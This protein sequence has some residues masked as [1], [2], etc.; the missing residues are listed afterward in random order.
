MNRTLRKCLIG[1][2]FAGGMIVLSATAANAADTTSGKDGIL[3]GTQVIAPL[4]A[5]ISTGATSLGLLG[6][7]AATASAPGAAGGSG[8]AP[9]A[10]T[11]GSSSIG[12]GTQVVAPVTVPMNLGSS[13]VGLLGGSTVASP[14]TPAAPA[15]ATGSTPAAGTSGSGGIASGTQ[16]VAPVTVP[17]TVGSTSAGVLGD[18][19][20]TTTPAASVPAPAPAPA[21]AQATTS[22]GESIASGAQV[23]AP[24]SV[25][26][27]IGATAV[28]V[29]G[30]SAASSGS[31]APV[32]P[33]APSGTSSGASTNG[34][35]GIGSG[36][37]VVAPITAP[38]NVG[39]TS[40]GVLGDS[41]AT[42]T[43]TSGGGGPAGTTGGSTTSGNDGLL[44]GTQ[45]IVPITAPVRVG[46]TSVGVGGGSVGTV[47]PPVVTLPVVNPP[48]VT[49][50]VVN[51][52]V[53]TPPVVNPPVVTP[54]VVNPPT[55][56]PPA[57]G[58]L[59]PGGNTGID[60]AGVG[61]QAATIVPVGS[62]QGAITAAAST[63]VGSSNALANTGLNGTV[64]FWAGAML[65]MGLLLAVGSRRK[66]AVNRR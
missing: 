64:V 52:P 53:V 43:G 40:A 14:A 9:A 57:G 21:P 55:V 17:I 27:N 26:V 5:P 19:S 47:T 51:P 4:T 58:G 24:I 56:N 18:S 6:D 12:S 23:V 54:P 36:T 48:V 10:T 49:P 11:N 50:P 7:S 20:A 41:S 16:V 59:V 2:C 62:T 45:V 15:A 31:A 29:A 1:T 60:T 44:S 35:D 66:D 34:S 39:S 13:S 33:A 61:T 25:P 42:N 65:L 22:G 38:V 28:G 37:Q 8:H 3:S 46:S 30:D 32:A 63:A